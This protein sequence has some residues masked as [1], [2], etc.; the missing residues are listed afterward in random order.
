[1]SNLDHDMKQ[2]THSRHTPVLYF[3]RVPGLQFKICVA[4]MGLAPKNRDHTSSNEPAN[5]MHF[6]FGT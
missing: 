3:D 5:L 2:S 1:M 4:L 6:Q